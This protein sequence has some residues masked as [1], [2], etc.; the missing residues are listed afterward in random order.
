MSTEVPEIPEFWVP[1]V[2]LLGFWGIMGLK[3][4]G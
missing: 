4:I 2:A 3:W 1:K